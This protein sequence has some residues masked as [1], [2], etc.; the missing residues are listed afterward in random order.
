MKL[1]SKEEQNK[2]LI[3]ILKYIDDICRKNDIK[4]TLIGGS[5]IGAIRHKGMIPWDDDID[6]I[7]L[8]PEYDK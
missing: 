7:L 5:L 4:Y 2:E 3:R 6:I 8:K 1:M